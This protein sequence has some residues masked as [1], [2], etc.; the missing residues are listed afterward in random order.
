MS[1]K[2]KIAAVALVTL[3]VAGGLAASSTQ[4]EAK[5]KGVGVGIAAGAI[6][7]AGL[8]GAA[9]ASGPAYYGYGGGYYNCR[10]VR[11]YNQFGYYIGKTKVCGYY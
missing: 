4:A 7:G 3:T 5:W 8:A 11:Q 1:I 2:T 9:Y 10:W 6:I